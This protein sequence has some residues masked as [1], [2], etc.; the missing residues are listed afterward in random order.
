MMMSEV[1]LLNANEDGDCDNDG[2]DIGGGEEGDLESTGKEKARPPPPQPPPPKKKNKHQKQNK[3]TSWRRDL[4]AETE[5]MDYTWEQLERLAQDRDAW[6]AVV[7]D[8]CSSRGPKAMMMMM[9][10]V[11][12]MTT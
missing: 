4:K 11:M 8:L 7:G 2:G 10:I 9:M 1:K 5:R 6:T 3:K 12:M